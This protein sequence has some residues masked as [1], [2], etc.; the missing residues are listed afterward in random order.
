MAAFLAVRNNQHQPDKKTIDQCKISV[1][2]YELI[3]KN[4][5]QVTPLGESDAMSKMTPLNSI[6]G[7]A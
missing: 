7:V 5:C 6:K 3:Q 2:F 4:W 1:T